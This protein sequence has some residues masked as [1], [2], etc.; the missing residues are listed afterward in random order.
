MFNYASLT[1]NGAALITRAIN[2]EKFVFTRMEYGNGIPSE[3]NAS[4]TSE[5]IKSILS[6]R[7]SLVSKKADI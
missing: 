3:F 4:Q 7:T 2:G 1:Q 6:G 5:E